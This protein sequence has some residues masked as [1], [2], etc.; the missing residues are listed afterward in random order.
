MLIAIIT[1]Q[2]NQRDGEMKDRLA[3][4]SHYFPQSMQ[5]DSPVFSFLIE[6]DI[7]HSFRVH[8]DTLV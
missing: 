5:E 8:Y 3:E 6:K 2:V 4:I 7:C 1:I